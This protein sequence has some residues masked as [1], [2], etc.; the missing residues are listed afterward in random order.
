MDDQPD[1]LERVHQRDDLNVERNGRPTQ[2]Q[3][4]HA[5]EE[6]SQEA[7]VVTAQNQQVYGDD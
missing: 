1:A 4:D 3:Y 2:Q 5:D 7:E 6:R